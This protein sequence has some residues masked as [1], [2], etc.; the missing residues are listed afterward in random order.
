M[1]VLQR[2]GS[3]E[4]RQRISPELAGI[5]T[6]SRTHQISLKLE[7]CAESVARLW[8][9]VRARAR[10]RVRV[11]GSVLRARFRASSLRSLGASG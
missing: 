10:A 1:K 9:R 6:G 2:L 7:D 5:S 3:R 11:L 8:V 4:S